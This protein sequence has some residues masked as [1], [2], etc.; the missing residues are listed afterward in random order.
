MSNGTLQVR[1]EFTQNEG[2]EEGGRASMY[3]MIWE[4]ITQ[5]DM[6][7]IA[8][9]H[10]HNAIVSNDILY[11]LSAHND[12]LEFLYDYGAIG[13]L[14]LLL[15]Q[16]ELIKITY[17]TYKY[18]RDFLSTIFALSSIIVLSMVSVVYA[19]Y[20]FLVIIPFWCVINYSTRFCEERPHIK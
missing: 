8:I 20:Y 6:T 9:G 13:L 19:F 1:Y 2:D 3:P 16:W 17:R 11:G 4:A 5:S 12:Y 10:G 15:Y 18:N 7:E 14:L